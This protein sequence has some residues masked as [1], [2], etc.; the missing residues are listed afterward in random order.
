MDSVT[1]AVLGASIAGATLGRFH[2]RRIIATGALLATVPDLDVIIRYSDPIL[3]MTHHRGFSHSVFVLSAV[4]IGLALLWRLLRPDPRYSA[5]YLVWSLWL[6]LITHP[7]LDALTSYGTQLLWPLT[8]T[9]QAWGSLFIIDPFYTAPLLLATLIG[10]IVGRRPLSTK[11]CVWAL[12]LSTSY[13]GLSLLAQQHVDKKAHRHVIAQGYTPV[14]SFTTPQPFSILLW[15]SVVRTT[16]DM[17]C[18]VII[19]IFDQDSPESWCAANNLHMADVLNPSDE[20]DRLRWFNNNWVR[21]DVRDDL[22]I[23]SDLRMGMGP[24]HYSFRFVVGELTH[25]NTWQWVSPYMWPSSRD[26]AMLRPVM[27]RIW[28][29]HPPLPLARWAKEARL[30]TQPFSLTLH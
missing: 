2:G 9:P 17:D 19:G 30:S 25:T 12:A 18:E 1:Q 28:N 7:L 29:Q 26:V 5:T 22:L 8:P 16:D 13:I 23:V 10:L 6:I 15:R 14:R 21:F 11:A 20:L 27:Q 24:G 3:A 4:A